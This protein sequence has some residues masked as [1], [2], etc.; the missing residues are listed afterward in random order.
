MYNTTPHRVTGIALYTLMFGCK[1]IIPLDQLLQ[2]V[3]IES[4]DEEFVENQAK[5]IQ[6][7]YWI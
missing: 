3:A 5:F 4:W 2:N 7:A 1:P 6:K